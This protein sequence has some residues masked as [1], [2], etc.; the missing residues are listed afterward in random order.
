MWPLTR[1]LAFLLW[2]PVLVPIG[3]VFLIARYVGLT[4]KYACTGEW[5][6]EEDTYGW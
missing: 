2:S 4:V 5:G 1:I 3:G 6:F